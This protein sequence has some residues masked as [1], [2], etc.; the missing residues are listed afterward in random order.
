MILLF[1]EPA[2]ALVTRSVER[3]RR[4]TP[5]IELIARCPLYWAAAANAKEA[6]SRLLL[7]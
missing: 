7:T 4:L 3:L 6:F 1:V 2:K 5:V